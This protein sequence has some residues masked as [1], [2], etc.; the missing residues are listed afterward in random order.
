MEACKNMILRNYQDDGVTA[1]RSD[2]RA[3]VKRICYTLPT[4][5]GKTA[6]YSY[7]AQK[8]SEKKNRVLIL[9][10]RKEI[11]EQTLKALFR[12]GVVSGQIAAGR[13][14]TQDGIQTAMVG[15]LVRRL[16]NMRRPDLIITDEC[17]HALEDNSWGKILRYWSD[18]P[19]IGVTA[20]PCRLDGRGLF[21]SFD[22]LIR[23]PSISA[24]TSDG[25]LCPP[26]LYRPPDEIAQQYHIKRGDFDTSE[27]VNAMSGRK[28]VGDVIE[29]YREHL[30][31]L[32]VVCFCISIE[33]SR[34][35]AA[36]FERAG[37][38]ARVV[39]GNMPREEREAA[40]KGLADGSVQVVT[41]CDVISEGVAISG[42]STPSAPSRSS[43]L[44]M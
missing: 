22:S 33:H 34:L 10:H 23:G 40:I 39:W 18:V 12:L 21:E 28:I 1:I 13:A 41:S 29:H 37:Y 15:T 16:G 11:L 20:T 9:V 5:G 27:Q 7:I 19:N 32:P 30:D 26:V 31:G 36:Q 35:M 2:L 25:W 43:R 6:I 38:R 44:A 14:A 42:T 3:G 8:S 17:H 4:G 24:L